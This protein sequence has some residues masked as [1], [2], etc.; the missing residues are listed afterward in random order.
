M[1]RPY[2]SRGAFAHKLAIGIFA[3]IVYLP[4]TI[5]FSDGLNLIAREM[6]FLTLTIPM[7]RQLILFLRTISYGAAVGISVVL[8]GLIAGSIIWSCRSKF[9]FNFVNLLFGLSLIMVLVPSYVHALAW[10]SLLWWFSSLLDILGIRGPQAQGI[11]ASWWVMVMALIPMGL[12][13]SLIGYK[14]IDNTLVESG[15]ILKD[16]MAVFKN[17]ILPLALPTAAAGGIFAFLLTVLDYSVPS[18][19]LINTY[20]LE[21]F[22]EFSA[23][24]QPA[25]AFLLS[26]PLMVVTSILVYYVAVIFPGI[27]SGLTKIQ[28]KSLHLVFPNWFKMLQGG[29][30]VV[31]FLQVAIPLISL[32]LKVGNLENF[33]LSLKHAG[34]E[35]VFTILLSSVTALTAIILATGMGVKLASAKSSKVWWA[36]A[37]LPLALPAPLAGIGII[38]LYSKTF[39]QVFYGSLWMPVMACLVRFM[40]LAVV[41]IAVQIKRID[42]NLLDAARVFQRNYFHGIFRINLPLLFP[43]IAAAFLITFVLT[44]GELGATLIVVP[45]GYSTLTM[46]IYNFMHY[47]SSELIAGLCLSLLGISMVFGFAA[48][49]ILTSLTSKGRLRRQL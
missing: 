12:G 7:G 48:Y 28:N 35:L 20:S 8:I 34:R 19:F 41:V 29:F 9:M 47:G 21:I 30:L 4:I 5:L 2:S 26:L 25:R 38:A 13:F 17:I 49:L 27:A 18:L 42:N 32:V 44:A 33:L 46:R 24:N 37:A 16:D 3:A 10:S 40:P 45:P 31:I 39:L 15:R 36:F 11:V 22:A 6:D 43:G 23:T 14:C 1:L